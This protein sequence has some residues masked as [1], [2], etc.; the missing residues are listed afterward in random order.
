MIAPGDAADPNPPAPAQPAPDPAAPQLPAPGLG[1]GEELEEA[2]ESN[3][4]LAL[5]DYLLA[6]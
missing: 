1:E 2:A 5:L 6:P 3:E 4:N